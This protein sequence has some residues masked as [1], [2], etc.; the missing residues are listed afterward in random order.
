MDKNNSNLFLSIRE[1]KNIFDDFQDEISIMSPNGEILYINHVAE[2]LYG[3]SQKDLIGKSADECVKEGYWEDALYHD[4]IDSGEKICSVQ[5]HRSGK[6]Y[7]V[8]GFPIFEDGILE[9]ILW[10]KKGEEYL[11]KPPEFKKEISDDVLIANSSI[12]QECIRAAKKIGNI[13]S[14]VMILGETGTGKSHLAKYIHKQSNRCNTPFVSIN[15]SAIPENLFE[16]ELFGYEKGSFTGASNQGK[17]GLVSIAKGGTLFLDEIG[18][19]PLHLQPKLLMLL[20][21]GTFTPVGGTKALT[22]DI[23]I[24]TATNKN[25]SDMMKEGKFREDL[26][27]RLNI[28]DIK[29]PALRNRKED[30]APLA[31]FFLDKFNR[32][33]EKQRTLS[34]GALSFLEQ[35]SWPGNVRELSNV[36]EKTVILND[37]DRIEVADLPNSLCAIETTLDKEVFLTKNGCEKISLKNKEKELIISYYKRLKSSYKVADAL[38]ISQS[39]ATTIIR[40]YKNSLKN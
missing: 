4:V 31:T 3:V 29:L 30:I 15:C 14:T 8:E 18:D 6:C 20:Q 10:H 39:K 19:M 23:R 36:I 34:A 5:K 28:I 22:A 27:Y 32:K 9:L 1:I 37:K 17:K 35:Y 21:E 26:F 38:G 40:E 11:G 24:I 33:Y 25:L 16:S 13:N 12:M 2:K 7:E